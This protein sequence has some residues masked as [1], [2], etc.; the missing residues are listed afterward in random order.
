MA[1]IPDTYVII[2]RRGNLE[3]AWPLTWLGLND[4]TALELA[5]DAVKAVGQLQLAHPDRLDMP[6]DL[7]SHTP[8]QLFLPTRDSPLLSDVPLRP[9]LEGQ[10]NT[11]EGIPE[12]A[13]VDIAGIPNGRN[14]P[15]LYLEL[16]EG[17]PQGV[18]FL[19]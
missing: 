17:A 4:V 6:L 12:E 2:V 11:Q 14:A 16:R 13:R 8:L 9:Q 1:P 15:W 18:I 10:W 19:G 7:N 3:M 5:W